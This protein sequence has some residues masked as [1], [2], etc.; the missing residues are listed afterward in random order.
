MQVYRFGLTGTAAPV[1][2]VSNGKQAQDARKVNAGQVFDGST[3]SVCPTPLLASGGTYRAL[4]VSGQSGYGVA[5]AYGDTAY[6]WGDDLDCTS[7]SAIYR[8]TI[9]SGAATK[10]AG[11][12]TATGGVVTHAVTVD[13]T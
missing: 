4:K 1:L 12:G 11:A 9:S 13:G 10:I 8:Y 6:L 5:G 7:S 2:T 3:E